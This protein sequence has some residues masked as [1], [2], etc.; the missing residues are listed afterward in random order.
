M[1]QASSK[2]KIRTKQ[3]TYTASASGMMQARM[4]TD[5]HRRRLES[6]HGRRTGTDAIVAPHTTTRAADCPQGVQLL[7]RVWH[8]HRFRYHTLHLKCRL[9]LSR[10]SSHSDSKCCAC[11]T[12][13]TPSTTQHHPAHC[14]SQ[15]TPSTRLTHADMCSI[16]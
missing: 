2:N 8:Q 1:A 4:R 6:L 16:L 15:T 5:I 14:M 12:S 13:P 9:L 7:I 3:R 10:T 11:Q